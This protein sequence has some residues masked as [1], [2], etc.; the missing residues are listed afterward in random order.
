M[1]GSDRYPLD[2]TEWLDADLDRI[3]N[4]ADTDDDNES[5]PDQ[6]DQPP[7]RDPLVPDVILTGA[8]DHYCLLADDEVVCRGLNDYGQTTVSP[9]TNPVALT[10][11][12]S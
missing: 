2:D 8:E 7:G 12:L 6:F 1:N 11:L 4:N 5:I 3:G 10:A 9:L